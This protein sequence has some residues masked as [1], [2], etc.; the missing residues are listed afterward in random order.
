MT[1]ASVSTLKQKIRTGTACPAD[2]RTSLDAYKQLLS[3]APAV[4]A[5]VVPTTASKTSTARDPFVAARHESNIS[6]P[7]LSIAEPEESFV[8]LRPVSPEG[9]RFRGKHGKLTLI[10]K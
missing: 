3:Q 9:E 1:S 4:A 10:R 2:S 6:S 5:T 7:N 8:V